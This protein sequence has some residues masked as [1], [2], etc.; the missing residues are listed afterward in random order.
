MTAG[1]SAF[2]LPH[3]ADPGVLTIRFNLRS[4]FTQSSSRPVS[5]PPSLTDGHHLA[6]L[7]DTLLMPYSLKHR[8]QHN[9]YNGHPTYRTGTE[10][11]SINLLN[12]SKGKASPFLPRG[13]SMLSALVRTL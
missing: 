2:V 10:S 9:C 12:E 7:W 1:G 3:L 4:H 11:W 13:P 8:I 5:R 6:V